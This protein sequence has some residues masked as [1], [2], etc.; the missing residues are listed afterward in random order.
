[1]RAAAAQSGVYRGLRR[2]NRIVGVLRYAVPALG[3]LVL[4]ALATQIYLASFSGRF[5]V[6]Q[7]T[8]TPDSITIDAPEYVGVL[9]DGSLYRVWAANARAETSNT[10]LVDLTEARLTLDRID[11][12]QLQ[13][14]AA[15]AFL[16][17][18]RDLTM[19]PGLAD[20]ADSTGTVGTL[21][22]SVFDWQTRQLTTRGPVAI[23]YADGSTVRA[24]GLV[25]DAEAIIWTF[26]RSV[27]TLPST[28]GEDDA[29]ASGDMQQ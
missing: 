10:D 7:V 26:S 24:E 11:G 16:D 19:V 14:D 17:T 27:V 12:V 4:V 6:G 25:Y 8:I 18:G 9:E 20:V 3:A 23:D 29:P 13:V 22:D 21:Y 1:M 2:R 5:G 15:T 28:P